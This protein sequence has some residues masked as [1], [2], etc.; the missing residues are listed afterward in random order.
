ME[1][2]PT[3][4]LLLKKQMEE[5]VE[6]MDVEER[7]WHAV[8]DVVSNL[9]G[10]VVL[11]VVEERWE[12]LVDDG[13]R[14]LVQREHSVRLLHLLARYVVKGHEKPWQELWISWS[15]HCQVLV[16]G[17]AVVGVGVVCCRWP[18]SYT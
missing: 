11:E 4:E 17:V 5:R 7:M 14:R 9:V 18:S 12:E 15:A 10:A 16:F 1:L 3:L 2:E 13:R 8:V 6:A